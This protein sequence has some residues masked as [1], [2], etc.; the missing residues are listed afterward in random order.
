MEQ[1]EDFEAQMKASKQE[2]EL[3]RGRR[4]RESEEEG[5]LFEML[6]GDVD[7]LTTDRYTQKITRTHNPSNVE[8]FLNVLYSDRQL[9]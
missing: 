2:Y 5:N 7:R 4:D 6:R 9:K 8:C 1:A 3:L